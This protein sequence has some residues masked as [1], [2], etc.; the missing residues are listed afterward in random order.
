MK[1]KLDLNQIAQKIEGAEF[2]PE[3][4]P[5]LIIKS[6]NPS[7]TIILF[8]KGKMVITGLKR[9]SEAK[10]I[11]DKVINELRE[12]GINLTNPKI[13]IESIK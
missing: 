3:R 4:F 10:Q 5:G 13:S 12:I 7:A 11:V 6:Q 8:S 9:T 2:N 1:K